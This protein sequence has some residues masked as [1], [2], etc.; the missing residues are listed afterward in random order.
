MLLTNYV[1][2]TV[3][4]MHPTPNLEFTSPITSRLR[5]RDTGLRTSADASLLLQSLL[6]LSQSFH[7]VIYILLP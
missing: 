1:A 6:D 3:I 4:S 2:G 5:Q 7:L